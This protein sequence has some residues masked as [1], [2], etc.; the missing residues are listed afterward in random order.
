MSTDSSVTTDVPT[1]ADAAAAHSAE[2]P[3]D[4]YGTTPGGPTMIWI[5]TGIFVAVAWLRRRYRKRRQLR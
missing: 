3:E 2:Q 4:D 5:F 1:P